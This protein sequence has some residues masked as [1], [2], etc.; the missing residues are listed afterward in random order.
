MEWWLD[1]CRCL[2]N[3][4]VSRFDVGGMISE[5]FVTRWADWKTTVGVTWGEG[6][7]W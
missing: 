1:L 3:D 6:L 7:V 4:V 5:G 2:A